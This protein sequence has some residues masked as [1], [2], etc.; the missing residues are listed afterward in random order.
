M[1]QFC[2][3]CGTKLEDNDN[4]CI[5][6]GT[7]V[8]NDFSSSTPKS[9]IREKAEANKELKRIA[10]GRLDSNIFFI[11]LLSSNG[12]TEDDG[13]NIKKQLKN[14]INAGEIK[15]DDV[16]D[17]MNQLILEYKSEKEKEEEIKINKLKK[18]IS[19]VENIIKETTDQNIELTSFE[20]EYISRIRLNNMTDDEIKEILSS[21]A[22]QIINVHEKIGEY[23]FIGRLN[24]ERGFVRGSLLYHNNAPQ[25]L[26][27]ETSYAY[28]TI[29]EDKIKIIRSE[30]ILEIHNPFNY[31]N[32]E[33]NRTDKN[34]YFRDINNISYLKGRIIVK[35]N[36]DIFKI[37]DYYFKVKPVEDF[38]KLLNEKWEN[39]KNN[40]YEKNTT[41]NERDEYSAAD[42]LMKYAELYEKGLLSE[43]EFNAFKKKL[44]KL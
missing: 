40:E 16:E 33:L 24:E 23:D 34:L 42:E 17:R 6:C 1:V 18:R 25:K 27:D 26:S 30:N 37:D 9:K 41:K 22:K 31:H 35:L 32:R 8:H 4:F 14:E 20:K 44:L 15:K 12:L 43:E 36:R 10:G 13:N 38:Y 29:C 5:N 3:N 21:N 28:F 11:K 39:F 2:T 7:K 19:Y